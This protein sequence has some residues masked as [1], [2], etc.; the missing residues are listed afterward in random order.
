MLEKF[1]QFIKQTKHNE[2]IT[3]LEMSIHDDDYKL[4]YFTT[5]DGT[6]QTIEER[7]S[8]IKENDTFQLFY[9]KDIPTPIKF[10][11]LEGNHEDAYQFKGKDDPEFQKV[12]RWK[13][14][15]TPF[16][17]LMM[18][19][20]ADYP[21]STEFVEE[22]DKEAER[23]AVERE[24]VTSKPNSIRYPDK[25]NTSTDSF[26][27]ELALYDP[28]N[29]EVAHGGEQLIT[30]FFDISEIEG[31]PSH[32]TNENLM[33]LEGVFNL[34]LNGIEAFTP[35]VLYRF[36]IGAHKVGNHAVRVTDHQKERAIASV[37]RMATIRQELDLTPYI[38]KY[39]SKETKAHL[40]EEPEGAY[41]IKSYMLPV[42]EVTEKVQGVRQKTV[43]RLIQAPAL[44]KYNDWLA[45]D[46]IGQIDKELLDTLSTRV[47]DSLI[48]RYLAKRLIALENPNN[49]ISNPVI[50]FETLYKHIDVED[51]NKK[52]RQSIRG[53]VCAVLDYWK[54][55]GRL[56]SDPENDKVGYR[57][58][59]KGR[60]F[61]GVEIDYIKRSKA[62]R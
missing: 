61:T 39:G 4:T 54:S 42:E 10:K 17:Y 31:L 32:L 35:E 27:N 49:R 19:A 11:N 47:E 8:Y 48:K 5:A 26:I 59:K 22:I 12:L 3:D 46:R 18:R 62:I 51:P 30:G 16:E 14:R 44:L 41:I 40:K 33:F 24:I 58:V 20:N 2:D 23:I 21:Y 15:L 43:Y 60:T 37:E 1:E 34:Y 28:S 13:L 53:K 50:N 55:I 56:K 57:L 25:Y 38:K 52:K 7:Y 45:N 29:I 9:K 6:A 36:S